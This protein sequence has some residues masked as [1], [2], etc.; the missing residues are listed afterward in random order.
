M[1]LILSGLRCF[2]SLLSFLCLFL[3][4]SFEK[5]HPS[6]FHELGLGELVSI[7][8]DLCQ[9]GTPPAIID[10]DE[11]QR[12][13][14]VSLLYYEIFTRKPFLLCKKILMF[15]AILLFSGYTTQSL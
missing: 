1:G 9:M 13:P 14:E 7:Y 3:Q 4:P 10:A 15:C 11:L 6:S 12:D 8:S 2:L 5:I